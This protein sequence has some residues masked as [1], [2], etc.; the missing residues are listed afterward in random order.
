MVPTDLTSVTLGVI[1]CL[2][3]MKMNPIPV[4]VYRF[5]LIFALLFQ[6][7]LGSQNNLQPWQALYFVLWTN[8]YQCY[9]P[10]ATHIFIRIVRPI[11]GKPNV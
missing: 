2:S 11:K 3:N 1:L 8:I 5:C 4:C 6:T 7:T 9:Q 10:P